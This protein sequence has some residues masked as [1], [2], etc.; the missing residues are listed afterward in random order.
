MLREHLST[1]PA[2]TFFL[3]LTSTPRLSA[4]GVKG[5]TSAYSEED[6]LK[7]VDNLHLG[8]AS[9]RNLEARVKDLKQRQD[10]LHLLVAREGATRKVLA[11]ALDSLRFVSKSI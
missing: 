5:L 3:E 8:V 1:T 4:R 10:T 7:S 11:N 6:L 9:R 2:E